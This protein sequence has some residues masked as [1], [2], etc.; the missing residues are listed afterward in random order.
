[1]PDLSSGLFGCKQKWKI[2][3]ANIPA[4]D[5]TTMA[6]EIEKIQLRDNG[7]RRSG[8]D[9]RV[10]SY[11]GYLPERRSGKERRSGADR[12]IIMRYQAVADHLRRIV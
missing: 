8:I 3:K 7:G 10:F 6:Q 5:R 4:V 12:R 9:R 1:M 2:T 11:A